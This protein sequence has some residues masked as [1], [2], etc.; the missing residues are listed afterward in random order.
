MILI[1]TL[2]R[3]VTWRLLT[4]HY[5]I[6]V[7]LC[8]VGVYLCAASRCAFHQFQKLIFDDILLKWRANGKQPVKKKGKS[9]K[10]GGK[11]PALAVDSD[12][13]EEPPPASEPEEGQLRSA[14]GVI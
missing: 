8:Y 4:S 3:E 12:S 14:I 2:H 13:D 7:K 6:I 11:R 5:F 9:K 10:T 1:P